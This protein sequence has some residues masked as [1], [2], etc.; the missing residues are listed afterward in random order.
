MPDGY[1]QFGIGG[2]GKTQLA[3]RVAFDLSNKVKLRADEQVRH[4]CDNPPCCNPRHLLRGD[5]AKN[6][7]D[8]E[9]RGRT[10]RGEAHP[11]A[12]LT[13]L[14]A[15]TI[16][17]MVGLSGKTQAEIGALFGITQSQVSAICRF[18]TWRR[19]RLTRPVIELPVHSDP[20]GLAP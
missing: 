12:K 3:H 10:C 18:K 9:E 11:F 16:R 5:N 13:D 20:K 7:A 14:D 2:R 15:R 19:A 1:G 6:V 17:V 8:R 4:R